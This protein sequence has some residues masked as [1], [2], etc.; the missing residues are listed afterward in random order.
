MVK[1]AKSKSEIRR[2]KS[3][4]E[5]G[6]Q[7]EITDEFLPT[8]KKLLLDIDKPAGEAEAMFLV[9]QLILDDDL[10]WKLKIVLDRVI[11]QT[12]YRYTVKMVFNEQPFLDRIKEMEEA[13]DKELFPQSVDDVKKQIEELKAERP[14]IEF[15]AELEQLKYGSGRTEIMVKIPDD[16][17]GALNA[18]KQYLK[19][20]YIA[21]LTPKLDI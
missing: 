18:N 7:I 17:I 9:K 14:E 12:Y 3:I 11:T 13:E 5:S 20:D 6:E 2:V 8:D 15:L 16:V 1:K 19:T 10:C 4:K 21:K